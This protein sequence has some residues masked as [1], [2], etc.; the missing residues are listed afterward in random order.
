MKKVEWT[1]G[2]YKLHSDANFNFQLNRIQKLGVDV[3]EVRLLAAQVTDIPSY[4]ALT[5]QAAEKAK[6]RGDKKAAI[7]YLRAAEFYTLAKD[8]KVALYDE[9]IQLYNEVNAEMLA[10][11]HVQR[12]DVPYEKGCLPVLYCLHDNPKG[13]VVIHGGFDSY[14]QEHLKFMIYMYQNGYSAYIFEGPGQGEVINKHH[15]PFTPDWHKPVGAI[16]DYFKLK[17]VALVG[18]SLGSLLCKLAAAREPRI[19]YL[20]ACG[21]LIDA[22]KTNTSR[23]PKEMKELITGL[24][25]NGK[26]DE[27]NAFMYDLMSKNPAISWNQDHGMYVM[28]EDNPYDLVR[29]IKE[30]TLTPQLASQITQDFLLVAG[31]NDHFMPLNLTHDEIDLMTNARSFTLRIITAKELGDDHCN[32]SNRKLMLDTFIN[33]MEEIKKSAAEL[34][35]ALK[36]GN[37]IIY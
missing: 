27:Y 22:Y 29:R 6:A 28:G 36:N 16:L 1:V 11:N 35:A 31:A 21:C 18:I 23:M 15:I 34:E 25:E 24:L 13:V 7:A 17:D 4:I 30:F 8:G 10:D 37:K 14:M 9:Y 33:W 26:K 3:E 32:V 5:R 20:F 19:K 2:N 12:A